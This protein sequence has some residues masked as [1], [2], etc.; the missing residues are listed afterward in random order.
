MQQTFKP[1]FIPHINMLTASIL[2]I[3]TFMCAA[4]I[5]QVEGRNYVRGCYFTNWAQYR[6]QDGKYFPEDYNTG[7]CDFIFYAFARL[8]SDFTVT[9]FEWNDI[10]RL[11]PALMKFKQSQPDLKV[12]LSVG[13]WNAGTATFKQLA[14]SSSGRKKFINSVVSFIKQHNFDGLD[15]DWEYPD[16]A[17]KINFIALNKELHERFA[18][19]GKSRSNGKLYLTAAVTL[20]N[21]KV[22]VGYDVKELS[23][24]WDFMNLMSYDVHGAWEMK[25]GV[26]SPLYRRSTDPDWAKH[27]NIEGSA[28]YWNSKGMPKEKII[29][30]LATYGR[31]WT[32]ASTWNTGV[33]AAATGP[34][35]TSPYLGEAGIIAYYEVCQRL[36]KGG[37]R[38]W[39]DETKTPYLVDGNQ[40]FT[41]D[42]AQSIKAKLQWLM[43]E[44]YGGAFVWTLDYDDFKG[45]VCKANGGKK[46]PLVSLMKD[47]LGSGGGDHTEGTIT[48]GTTSDGEGGS[49]ETGVSSSETET[50]TDY[51]T[52]PTVRPPPGPFQC[53][54]AFGYFEDPANCSSFY[55]CA[56]GHPYK[57]NCQPGLVFNPSASVCDWP[58]NHSCNK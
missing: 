58:A 49:E 32:L 51:S 55:Q 31:G 1:F 53:P 21:A 11:Y 42:D 24:Y 26:N 29:I 12:L 44:G 27:W 40:W 52:E 47:L 18:K 13:G 17:D 50:P 19:E 10:D 3:L 2:A 15:L 14:Q 7:L 33:N 6:Q 48:V 4:P 36:A 56:H 34:S 20:D 39:D 16:S 23:K 30:G 8:N 5:L 45:T 41:Y 25:T 54:S 46:Y 38:H 37:K 35:S 57:M 22:D 28:K 9:N 43:K